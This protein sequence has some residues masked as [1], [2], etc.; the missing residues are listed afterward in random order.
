MRAERP[1]AAWVSRLF[2]ANPFPTT[3]LKTPKV[4][5]WSGMSRTRITLASSLEMKG[6]ALSVTLGGSPSF[7]ALPIK[8]CRFLKPSL[9]GTSK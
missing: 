8:S 9:P 3:P 5:E 7:N 4:V 6:P 1:A 2:R